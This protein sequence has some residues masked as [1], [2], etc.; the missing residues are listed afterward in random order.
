[1]AHRWWVLV[2]RHGIVIGFDGSF[3][4]IFFSRFAGDGSNRFESKLRWI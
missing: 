2:D 1:M 4:G 3:N